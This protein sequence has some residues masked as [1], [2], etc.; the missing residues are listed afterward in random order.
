MAILL[1]VTGGLGGTGELHAIDCAA[2][3]PAASPCMWQDGDFC[4][5]KLSYL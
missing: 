4:I 1:L 3:E 5:Q 2:G